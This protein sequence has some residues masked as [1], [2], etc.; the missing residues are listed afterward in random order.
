MLQHTSFLRNKNY[1]IIRF[2]TVYIFM[3]NLS[4]LNPEFTNQ[5]SLKNY[6]S[7]ENVRKFNR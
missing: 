2:E 3:F 7:Y 1:L 5:L 4:Y 6:S